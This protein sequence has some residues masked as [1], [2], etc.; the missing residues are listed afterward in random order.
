MPAP[1][2]A[3]QPRAGGSSQ[4]EC[5]VETNQSPHGKGA[6]WEEKSYCTDLQ[7]PTVA[8]RPSSVP[9]PEG[10]T[11]S[12][13]CFSSDQSLATRPLK[14]PESQPITESSGGFPHGLSSGLLDKQGEVRLF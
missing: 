2:A 12:L 7:V 9:S 10:S 8:R 4:Q 11:C 6:G 3:F 14:T 13:Q 5:V 1:S